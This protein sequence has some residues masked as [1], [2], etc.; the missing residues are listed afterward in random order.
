MQRFVSKVPHATLQILSTGHN[1]LI[2]ESVE[3]LGN[4]SLKKA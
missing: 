1:G 3:V 4:M 2:K